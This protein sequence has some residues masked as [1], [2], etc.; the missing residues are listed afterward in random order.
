MFTSAR[1]G[2]FLAVIML[3]FPAAANVSAQ[4]GQPPS[5]PNAAPSAQTVASTPATSRRIYLDIA[6]DKSGQAVSGLQQQDFT[7]LDNK[8][9]QTITSFAVVNGR[10]APVQ[11]IVVMDAVNAPY[12]NVE[13]QRQ[14]L[15]KYLRAEGGNLAYPM[16]IA[17]LADD[18]LHVVS[19]KFLTDGN[20]L[21][22]ALDQN[23]VGFRAI[24][25]S[26]G[27]YGA[28][29][30]YQ[31][32]LTAMNR[33]VRSVAQHTG[34][35]VFIWVSPGWPLLSGPEVQ[36]DAKQ[37]QQVFGN[38]VRLANDMAQARITL[39]SIDPLGAA[40]APDHDWAY[41]QFIK[42]VTKLN[43]VVYGDLGLPVLAVQSGGIAFSSTNGIAD[44]L[45]QCL[46]DAVPYYEISFDP[47]ASTKKD[48]YHQLQVKVAGDGLS[49]R[50]R[51][52]YYGQP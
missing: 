2:G 6:V 35:K 25:R 11:V 38:I 16:T 3:C 23:Q 31:I 46:T 44:R 45:R 50:T 15:D 26:S 32:C 22:T 36:L 34:R 28:A 5:Q 8:Q 27:Y 37:E 43:Q 10:E 40:G 29:E 1:F 7:L 21:S 19:S 13:F 49:A 47:P 42:G 52:G 41:G 51:Q 4:T 24:T 9:P 30:R 14:Q 39:Y 48:E 33:L 17:L 20:A 18:G 12:Q